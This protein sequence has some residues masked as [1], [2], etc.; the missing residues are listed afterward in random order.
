MLFLFFD[1]NNELLCFSFRHKKDLVL[2]TAAS[3][4]YKSMNFF[5]Q[6]I[7]GAGA[8]LNGPFGRKPITYVDHTASGRSL[9]SIE[10]FIRDNVLPIYGNTHTES[11]YCGVQTTVFREEARDIIREVSFFRG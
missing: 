10:N 5:E 1:T 6:D 3:F 9:E 4:A 2:K 11:S 7:I 8:C